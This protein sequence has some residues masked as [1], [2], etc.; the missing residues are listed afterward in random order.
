MI[1]IIHV[2][3]T[4]SVGGICTST[5]IILLYAVLKH[6]THP[7]KAVLLYLSGHNVA[8]WFNVP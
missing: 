6:L 2:S 7:V 4:Q 1:F 3:V 8:Q 5:N